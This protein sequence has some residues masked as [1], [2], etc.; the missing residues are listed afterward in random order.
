MMAVEPSGR[1]VAVAAMD[2]GLSLFPAYRGSELPGDILDYSR[3]ADY[4]GRDILEAQGQA[5]MSDSW[6]EDRVVPAEW[7]TIWSLCFVGEFH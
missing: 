2:G 7:G 3:R 1:A 4:D 5:A 6:R